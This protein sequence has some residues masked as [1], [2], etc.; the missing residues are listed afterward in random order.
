MSRGRRYGCL[1][2]LIFSTSPKQ[3]GRGNRK[4]WTASDGSAALSSPPPP[5]SFGGGGRG[6]RA[7]SGAAAMPFPFAAAE[8]VADVGSA[9]ARHQEDGERD[10]EPHREPAR[11]CQPEVH[12]RRERPA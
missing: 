7:P 11:E 10:Q 5:G 8:D 6:E 9:D 12:P 2:L 3:P 4:R 1:S